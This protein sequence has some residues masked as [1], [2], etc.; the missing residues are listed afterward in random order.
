MS[1]YPKRHVVAFGDE[2][3]VEDDDGEPIYGKEDDFQRVEVEPK[4]GEK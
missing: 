4:E 3:N 1:D 2:D